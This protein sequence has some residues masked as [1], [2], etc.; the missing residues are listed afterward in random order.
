VNKD[1]LI[2]RIKA[3]PWTYDD[4]INVEHVLET[5]R[6]CIESVTPERQVQVLPSQDTNDDGEAQSRFFRVGGRNFVIGRIES[7]TKALLG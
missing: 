4:G 3:T 7:N 2:A 6:D 5:I 1:Q